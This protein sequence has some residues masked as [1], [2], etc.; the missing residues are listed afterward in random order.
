MI[1]PWSKGIVSPKKIK[2]K[3]IMEGPFYKYFL[4]QMGNKYLGAVPHGG[5]TVKSCLGWGSFTNAFSSNLKTV[6]NLVLFTNH[7]GIYT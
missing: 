7:E 5:A 6:Y 4:W 1:F 2:I 3:K